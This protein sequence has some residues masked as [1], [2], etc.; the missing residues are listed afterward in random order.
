[1]NTSPCDLRGSY[2]TSLTNLLFRI[3]LHI[4]IQ[5]ME[6]KS[7]LDIICILHIKVRSLTYRLVV[8]FILT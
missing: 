8:A 2:H 6:E 5:Y 3:V 4:N 7:Q 1:M